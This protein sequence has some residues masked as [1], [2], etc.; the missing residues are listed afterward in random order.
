MA[1]GRAASSVTAYTKKLSPTEEQ[2]VFMHIDQNMSR[3]EIARKTE[4]SKQ[5]VSMQLNRPHVQREIEQRREDYRIRMKLTREDVAEVFSD[6]INMARVMSE[7][8]TMIMGAREVGKMLGYYEPEVI[9]V[10][11]SDSAQGLQE[12]LRTLTDAELYALLAEAEKVVIDAV[13]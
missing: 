4:T 1:K 12:Q 9:K 13:D 5:A 3:N 11:M 10:Q 8:A 2:A 6:A 7:P